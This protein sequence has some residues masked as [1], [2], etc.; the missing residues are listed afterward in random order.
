MT[1]DAPAANDDANT[2]TDTAEAGP[3]REPRWRKFVKPFLITL[4][5]TIVVDL[6]SRF[7]LARVGDAQGAA[8]AIKS[9]GQSVEYG[10]ESV[11]LLE[12]LK[13]AGMRLTNERYHTA[14]A[15][16]KTPFNLS[17]ACRNGEARRGVYGVAVS[18]LC[19][20]PPPPPLHRNP[21]E[22]VIVSPIPP[23]TTGPVDAKKYPRSSL[24]EIPLG[25]PDTVRHTLRCAWDG[26]D[27]C[28]VA[29][30]GQP[31]SN[32]FGKLLL[33]AAAIFSLVV[34][35]SSDKTRQDE[36]PRAFS[37]VV[38]FGISL[39][40]A[41]MVCAALLL[42]VKVLAYLGLWLSGV[43]TALAGFPFAVWVF[44]ALKDLAADQVKGFV[45]KKV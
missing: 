32:W 18:N 39:V 29:R 40:Y 42:A 23:P 44:A 15:N 1:D 20:V 6:G 36:T 43:W 9:F 34:T 38:I 24:K 22:S 14:V 41:G 27:H 8:L 33:V 10:L 37:F 21:L 7:L 11:N 28:E 31:R 26:R 16:W 3:P 2:N 17:E 4:A 25:L 45:A 35:F 19:Y 13:R 12:T 5:F 30:A